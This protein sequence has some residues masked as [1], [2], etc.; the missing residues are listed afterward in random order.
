VV[1]IADDGREIVVGD[2][3][4]Q[5]PDL[6][7]IDALARMQ[8]CARRRG[9]AL[10]LRDVSEDLRGLLELVGLTEPLGLEARRQAE[11]GEQVGIEEVMQPRDPPA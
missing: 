6:A 9:W 5:R 4:A 10:Q 1:L 3:G 8:L 2:L 11:L 7:L